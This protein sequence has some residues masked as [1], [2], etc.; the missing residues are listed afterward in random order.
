MKLMKL[1]QPPRAGLLYS[2][3]NGTTRN[4]LKNQRLIHISYN[5]DYKQL[6]A[7]TYMN[8]Y[9]RVANNTS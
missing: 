1:H 6:I 2:H 9:F 5:I 3:G 8:E 7:T 4:P